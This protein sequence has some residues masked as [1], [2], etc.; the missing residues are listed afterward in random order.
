M[1]HTLVLV[2]VPNC[3]NVH[4]AV[5]K[6]PPAPPSLQ[7][8]VPVGILFVPELESRTFTSKFVTTSTIGA[9]VFCEMV[10]LVARKV[11]VSADVPELV[12]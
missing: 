1:V 6:L 10:S 3:V 8:T 11:T 5:V 7:D 12:L 4:E 9:A 2:E